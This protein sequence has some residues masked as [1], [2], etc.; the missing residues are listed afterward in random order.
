MGLGIGKFF[1]K[2]GKAVTKGG[3]N[4]S[5]FVASET[6]KKTVKK[7]GLAENAFAA[8]LKSPEFQAVHDAFGVGLRGL[9]R[10]AAIAIGSMGVGVVASSAV[11]VANGV[12]TAQNIKTL[13]TVAKV[14]NTVSQAIKTG[15]TVSK[16]VQAGA[17]AVAVGSLIGGKSQSAPA[18]LESTAAIAP[19]AKQ[20]AGF[21]PVLAGA[22]LLLALKR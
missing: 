6:A 7:Y 15:S 16:V 1:N 13:T 11:N 22:A 5:K 17:A 3:T 8:G 18:G 12:A 4:L 20:S 2:I 21:L 10:D 9:A 19:D 14:A